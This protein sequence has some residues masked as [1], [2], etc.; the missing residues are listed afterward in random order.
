[1]R[2]VKK[3]VAKIPLIVY[4]SF[5]FFR[6]DTSGGGIA[7]SHE[8]VF[9]MVKKNLFLALVLSVAVSGAAWA[10]GGDD[11]T[12]G[13][14]SVIQQPT[15]KADAEKK[16]VAPAGEE[17]KD[18]APAGEEKKEEA[19]PA[20]E[21]P[22]K[23]DEEKKDEEKAVKPG[24]DEKDKP[25]KKK[26][27]RARRR[28]HRRAAGVKVKP[29]PCVPNLEKQQQYRQG[30]DGNCRG[31]DGGPNA[32]CPSGAAPVEAGPSGQVVP[33]AEVPPAQ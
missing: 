10:P 5:K 31:R 26:K 11:K 7:Q 4:V 21:E 19:A 2:L 29:C 33:P 3:S 14:E 32:P 27:R 20:A 16:D 9:T 22:A 1:M 15:D 24:E 6:E 17:K 12:A 8:G 18:T 13:S 30:L 28:H 23:A 25:A